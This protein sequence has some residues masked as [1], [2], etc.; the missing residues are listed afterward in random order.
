MENGYLESIIS[1]IFEKIT[2]NL[3]SLKLVSVTT[4]N[5]RTD[6]TTDIHKEIRKS[7]NL[8]NVKGTYEKL[9]RTDL[10]K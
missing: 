1:K 7:M 5:A 8:L 3:V 10:T 6:T 9:W 2:K 4:T